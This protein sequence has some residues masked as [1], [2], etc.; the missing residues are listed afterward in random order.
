[1]CYTFQDQYSCTHY[2]PVAKLEC[3]FRQAANTVYDI[4]RDV[5]AYARWNRHCLE[6]GKLEV[7]LV[8]QNCGDCVRKNE[9]RKSEYEHKRRA[10][11]RVEMEDMVVDAEGADVGKEVDEDEEE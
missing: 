10:R 9:E 11:A 2:G 5:A 7:K 8:I 6:N 1:M 3:G 4:E